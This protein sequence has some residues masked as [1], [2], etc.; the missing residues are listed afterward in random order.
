MAA[1]AADL[2]AQESTISATQINDV[3]TAINAIVYPY[4]TTG[5]QI[6]LTSVKQNP[7]NGTQYVV[8]WSVAQNTTPRT[9]NTSVTIPTGLVTSGAS[10]ILAEIRY[11]YTPPSTSV[12]HSAFTMS[13]S[14]YARPRKGNFVVCT[15]G[16]P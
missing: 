2:V 1:S 4:P 11:N 5:A 10:V 7:N 16:C 12:I 14:F 15:S 9:K 13:D 6:V 3:F 8:D